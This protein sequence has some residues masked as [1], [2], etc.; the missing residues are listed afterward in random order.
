MQTQHNPPIRRVEYKDESSRLTGVIRV[1]AVSGDQ[2]V[3]Y[4]M[5]LIS[6]TRQILEKKEFTNPQAA[7]VHAARHSF[8]PQHW[9]FTHY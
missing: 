1:V 5:T 8:L 4:L 7:I 3:S 9:K 6:E 2:P